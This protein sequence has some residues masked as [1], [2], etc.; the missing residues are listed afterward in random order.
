[1][2][3]RGGRQE[4]ALGSGR[5]VWVNDSSNVRTTHDG[6]RVHAAV[7]GGTT[8]DVLYTRPV[9]AVAPGLAIMVT[10]MALNVLG[11]GVRDA[12]DPRARI[13]LGRRG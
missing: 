4:I 1:M 13:R 9:V 6:V 7:A 5:F 3:V 11:D 12:L 2:T 8:V 10:V